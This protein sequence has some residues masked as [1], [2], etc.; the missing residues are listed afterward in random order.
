[1]K[2]QDMFALGTV[3]QNYETQTAA[4][5]L[6]KDDFPAILKKADPSAAVGLARV[7]G[8]FCDAKL[9]DDSQ[10]FFAQ[11]NLPGTE[12]IL[13]NGKEQVNACIE[14]RTMQA[15]NLAAYLGKEA[16]K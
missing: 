5:Q 2:N 10:R 9:R 4:W 13:Q 1:V 14:L 11:Q 15:Q 8:V 12:R 16:R 6:F 3:L 7:S